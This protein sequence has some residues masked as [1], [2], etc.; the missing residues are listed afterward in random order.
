MLKC[1][2]PHIRATGLG[3][4]TNL[5]GD[6]EDD[7]MLYTF[8]A[9]LSKRP[10]NASRMADA[11]RAAVRTELTSPRAAVKSPRDQP[12]PL[13]RTNVIG[14]SSIVELSEAMV[15]I[16]L[17]VFS[18]FDAEIRRI[19]HTIQTR[20]SAGGVGGGVG[21]GQTSA[22]AGEELE[23]KYPGHEVGNY[24]RGVGQSPSLQGRDATGTARLRTP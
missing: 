10:L 17:G 11:A 12:A 21:A 8:A 13:V 16:A 5:P 22:G 15:S 4:T 14:I 24:T 1:E 20:S 7:M 19:A 2:I 6:F 18:Q 23:G 9:C 3:V